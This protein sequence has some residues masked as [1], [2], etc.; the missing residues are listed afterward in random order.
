MGNG[1][2]L[3]ELRYT[4]MK[5]SL[6]MAIYK[7]CIRAL[8]HREGMDPSLIEFT[9]EINHLTVPHQDSPTTIASLWEKSYWLC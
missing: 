1:C 6:D 5:E 8:S 7:D 2:G 3:P 4:F 9:A